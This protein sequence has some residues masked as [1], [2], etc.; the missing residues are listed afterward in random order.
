MS[1]HISGAYKKPI[2]DSSGMAENHNRMPERVKYQRVLAENSI[3]TV[4]ITSFCVIP[5]FISTVFA[6]VVRHKVNPVMI[7]PAFLGVRKNR[8]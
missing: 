4:H 1:L 8:W 5:S 3:A 7:C 2:T 6:V